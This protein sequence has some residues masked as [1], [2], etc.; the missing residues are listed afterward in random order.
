M[1]LLD[2]FMKED[3]TE[4]APMSTTEDLQIALKYAAAGNVAVLLRIRTKGCMQQGTDLTW[5]SAF[6]H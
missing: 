6:P 3:G 1:D 4:L 5:L 2:R